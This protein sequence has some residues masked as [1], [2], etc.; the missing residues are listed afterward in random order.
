[1]T[2][3]PT[4]NESDS[5]QGMYAAV[6]NPGLG[7]KR[8]TRR[9]IDPGDS[10]S[11]LVDKTRA[12][13][14]KLVDEVRRLGKDDCTTGEFYDG[15]LSRLVI[16]LA[17]AGGAI[18]VRE[19]GQKSIQLQCHVNLK[20]TLLNDDESA[21]KMH[22]K[23]V[24]RAFEN[25][26]DVLVPPASGSDV[27]QAVGNPTEHLLILGPIKVDNEVV[28][29]IE[30]FQRPGAGPA[31]QR[32]YQRF[33][34]QMSDITA[35]FLV[36]DRLR[37]LQE[38]EKTW[39]QLQRL[40]QSL[41]QRL[42]V[43]D[44]IY[45]IANEGRRLIDCDRVS[46]ATMHGSRCVVK[47][48]SGLDTIERRSDQ[49]KALGRLATAVVRSK[50]PLW[51]DGD[52]SSLAPKIEKRV[53]AHVEKSHSRM[54]AVIPLFRTKPTSDSG[55]PF[56]R[57]VEQVSKPVGA[58]I[59]EQL[60]EAEVSTQ[61]RRRGELVAMHA[62]TAL[63]N[64]IDHQSIFLLP[65]WKGIGKLV[66]QFQGARLIR[67]LG[68]IGLL[69]GAIGFLCWFPY[70]FSVGASGSLI[71]QRQT[72]VYA[73]L[74]GVLTEIHVSNSG[75]TLV[76]E[77]QLLATMASSTLELR[78]GDL[79]GRLA[80]AKEE[81]RFATDGKNSSQDP[82]ETAA[83]SYQYQRAQQTIVNLERERK[84][85]LK[86]QDFLEVRSPIAGQVVNWQVRQNLLRRPVRFGQHLMTVVPPDT[87][88]LIELEMPERRLAHLTRAMESSE[89]LLT[90][91]FA[92]LSWPGKE[93]EGELISVDQKLDVYSD[94]GNAALVRVRF[95]NDLI[96]EELRR[97]GTRVTGKVHCGTQPIG[98]A[99]FYELIE[100]VQSKWQFWF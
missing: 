98:Y 63:S 16:A 50:K 44:T 9:R 78:I 1:M 37:G 35:E 89:E 100:T 15:L 45:A 96:A 97:A 85:L 22:G 86:D 53:R 48:V 28:G 38:Q 26:S 36:R 19:A 55:D 87:Q 81:L 25:G 12:E 29:V 84:V 27:S 57:P 5:S 73:K 40:I 99:L 46:V 6:G 39:N 10:D 76:E 31:T 4:S 41:H 13:I 30:I 51:Y 70:P 88:W 3:D 60:S 8:K 47:S 92:L 21:R 33:V 65:L 58:L 11:A 75:D 52:N 79:D 71:P 18:W 14:R 93:F 83:Y 74:D 94:E 67:S 54:T 68:I 62:Q 66:R 90:V 43:K 61:L 24:E 95:S 17:S 34:A 82:E 56:E 2:H 49:V 91:T 72:E 20:Q 69:V 80:Q 7:S 32:G 59:V 77:G 42:D 64:S 23:L